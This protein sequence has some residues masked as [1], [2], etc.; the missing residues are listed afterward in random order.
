MV[1]GLT[2]TARVAVVADRGRSRLAELSGEPPLLPRRTGPRMG[3]RTGSRTGAGPVQV[4]LVGGA[5]G[6]LGGDRLRLEIEV[7]A[8]AALCLR[9]VAASVALPGPDGAES[10]L[11]VV[12]T[13]AAGGR[14]SWLPEPLIAAAGCRHVA[15]ADV[16]VAEGGRLVWR[17]EVVCG[18]HGEEPGDAV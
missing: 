8:G 11:D 10:R 6:P 9:T 14:L 18:R 4:H 13:V 1:G 17:D 5:A 3:P 16:T 12:A 7:G 15:A 2:A